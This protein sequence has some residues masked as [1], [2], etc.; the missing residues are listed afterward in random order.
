MIALRLR[1]LLLVAG[2]CVLLLTAGDNLRFNESVVAQTGSSP[3]VL[4][5][6]TASLNSSNPDILNITVSGTDRD[7]N[8]TDF[9][10]R[11]LDGR[12]QQI[13]NGSNKF[14]PPPNAVQFDANISVDGLRGLLGTCRVE[15]TVI[16]ATGSRSNPVTTSYRSCTLPVL[17]RALVTVING[18]RIQVDLT[19]G[20]PDGNLS[21]VSFEIRDSAGAVLRSGMF[22]FTTPPPSGP[23]FIFQLPLDGISL[24]NNPRVVRV[25]LIDSQGNRSSPLDATFTPI[26]GNPDIQISTF[27]INPTVTSAGAMVRADLVIVNR[28]D[29][30]AGASSTQIRLSRDN[31]I[32]STD[33]LLATLSVPALSP[34]QTSELSTMVTIPQNTQG[35]NLF[36]GAIADSGNQV[37][38]SSE[39]NNIQS[40]PITLQSTSDTVA[41]V[42]NVIAPRAGDTVVPGT[43]LQITYTSTDNVGVVANDISLS[44][45]AG[46]TFTTIASNLAGNI[47]Q[48]TFAVP[49][50]F[51][52]PSR[53]SIV[54]VTARDAGGN[55]GMGLSGTFNIGDFV[56]PTVRV[57]TPAGGETLTSGTQFTISFAAMDDALASVQASFSTDGGQ[58]FPSQNLIGR[59][60]PSASTIIWNIPD[61]LQTTQGVIQVT[62]RDRSGNVASAVSGQ[63]TVQRPPSMGPVLQVRVSFDPPPAGQIV[64]PQNLRA[65]AMEVR[66]N[67]T[68]N[69][70]LSAGSGNEIIGTSDL[71]ADQTAAPPLI[72]FNIYRV[73]QPPPDQ[74]QP[75]PDQIV[76][77][78]KNLVGSTDSNTTT[79]TDTVSTSKGS[80]FVY[81]VTS[82]FGNGS[83]SS[84][85]QPAGTNLPV[86][87]NPVFRS[88]TIFIDAAGSFI[89]PG[90]QLIVNDTQSY[91]LQFDDTNAFFTVPKKTQG[92]PGGL[93]FKKLVKKRATV[94]LVIKNADGKTSV[95]VSF[96]RP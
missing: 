9:I 82:F 79:F 57:L 15:V 53:Q 66:S 87:K 62:A 56:N 63:F 92:T 10:V 18:D 94:R 36:I 37:S 7:A 30:P 1:L 51:N 17:D 91:P 29:A 41:P 74:P 44:T 65:D 13:F 6:I 20:D 23:T 64:P 68:S 40:R 54:R 21:A 28:G 47:Q 76:N 83:Q 67:L 46:R 35:G 4:S 33:T 43:N 69:G 75:T 80:N 61:T 58:T 88:G 48:F 16:D 14:S 19:A 84:G 86:I 85:S 49:S 34:G 8:V 90:A 42:V 26:K 27:Q 45:D 70:T 81:S 60:G 3:P 59:A 55:T 78:P 93:T 50:D 39:T 32:D 52:P 73:P 72:G 96:T 89:K 2:L 31:T 5:T 24:L 95:G 71:P 38:E 25:Q 77:D 22:N 11:L 12:N